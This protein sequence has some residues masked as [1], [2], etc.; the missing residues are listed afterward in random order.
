MEQGAEQPAQA[1]TQPQANLGTMG[2]ILASVAPSKIVGTKAQQA[3]IDFSRIIK[4]AEEISGRIGAKTARAIKKDPSLEAP[5]N[6][7]LDTGEMSDDVARVL[8]LT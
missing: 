6:R 5:I 4:T 8:V 7:F 3:T 2:K 1:L